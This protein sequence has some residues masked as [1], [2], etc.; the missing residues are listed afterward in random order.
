MVEMVEY[1]ERDESFVRPNDTWIFRVDGGW[2][3][4]IEEYEDAVGGRIV[5]GGK[6]A[7]ESD[8]E[9]ISNRLGM[10]VDWQP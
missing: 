1:N 5:A 4:M 6:Y 8:V 3:V 7:S 9:E 2:R 10:P